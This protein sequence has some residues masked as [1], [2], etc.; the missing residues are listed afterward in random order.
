MK[1]SQKSAS[2][3][4]AM[5]S[6]MSRSVG[7]WLMGVLRTAKAQLGKGHASHAPSPPLC[8]FGEIQAALYSDTGHDGHECR[9]SQRGLPRDRHPRAQSSDPLGNFALSSLAQPLV[10]IHVRDSTACGYARRRSGR[11]GTV[12]GYHDVACS[13]RGCSAPWRRRLSPPVTILRQP[14]SLSLS[15]CRCR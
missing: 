8:P 7:L 15:C 11:S 3:P 5:G 6:I 10:S 4:N 1:R 9:G 12:S 14:S 2:A 13:R